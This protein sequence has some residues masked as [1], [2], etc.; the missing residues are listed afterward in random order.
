MHRG[1]QREPT[2]AEQIGEFARLVI[3]HRAWALLAPAPAALLGAW[4]LAG[5]PSRRA[6]RWL[7]FIATLWLVGVVTAVGVAFIQ[8]MKPLYQYQ[9]L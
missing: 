1:L 2:H 8:F 6:G 3:E 4:F 7:S 5:S 9:P